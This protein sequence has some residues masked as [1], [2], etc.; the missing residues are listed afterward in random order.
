MET[1]SA[2]LAI[3]AGNSPVTGEFPWQMPVTRSF[4]VFLDLRLNKLLS[5]QPWGW[6]FETPSCPL[7][8]HCKVI[9]P[10]QRLP[11]PISFRVS[12][13]IPEVTAVLLSCMK[14]DITINNIIGGTVDK[15]ADLQSHP[16]HRF[17]LSTCRRYMYTLQ[18]IFID[19]PHA[20]ICGG[21]VNM[22]LY[23]FNIFFSRWNGMFFHWTRHR[24]VIWKILLVR[25]IRRNPGSVD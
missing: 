13:S 3:C 6:W 2:L 11:V 10:V 25:K 24:Q 15:S 8:R 4:D 14:A 23:L 21:N 22:Y 9:E 16:C 1:F 17:V 20:E 19:H 12:I 18:S 7:W 5:K